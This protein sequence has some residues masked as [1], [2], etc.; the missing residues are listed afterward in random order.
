MHATK[1][2]KNLL[3]AAVATVLVTVS[4]GPLAAPP[5]KSLSLEVLSTYE[6]GLFDDGGA[7]I[8]TYEPSSQ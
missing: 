2:T 3:S 8:I 4:N 6:S 7:E 1:P 5:A